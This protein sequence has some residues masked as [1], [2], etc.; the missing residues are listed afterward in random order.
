MKSETDDTLRDLI[1]FAKKAN[2]EELVWKDDGVKIAFRRD[3]HV[4]AAPAASP[5]AE[6]ASEEE[7]PTE[8]IVRSPM[9][10]TFRR[11]VSKDRPPMVM[12][13]NHIKPGDRL[14]VV[15]CMKIPTD[16]VSFA[17]GE[18]KQIMVDDGQTV[19]YGQP[20]FSV[21]PF[22]GENGKE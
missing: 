4:V 15:E 21:T 19:E 3:P 13:G 2:L 5:A 14:G 1:Q 9:V 16:V 18:I 20:L 6:A 7:K 11:G 12:I 22:D 8:E 17:A 10:G